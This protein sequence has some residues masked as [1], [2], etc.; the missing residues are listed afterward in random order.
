MSGEHTEIVTEAEIEGV[1]ERGAE[2]GGGAGAE[3]E[4]EMQP[5]PVTTTPT[6]TEEEKGAKKIINNI[7]L[8]SIEEEENGGTP[9]TEIRQ[10]ILWRLEI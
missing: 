9:I 10:Y 6:T 4:A 5:T 3:A 8:I 7:P 2:R 1:G